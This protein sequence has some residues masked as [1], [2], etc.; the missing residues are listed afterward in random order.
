MAATRRLQKELA[1]LRARASPM[2][3]DIQ[4]DETNILSWNLLLLPTNDPYSDGAFKIEIVFPAEYPFK[5]PK[6]TFKTKIY[7]PNIDEKGQVCL[8]IISAENWKPATKT[9]QVLQALLALVHDPE[10][11]HPLRGDLA[12]LYSKNKKQFLTQAREYT[13]KHAEKRPT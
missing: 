13:K 3:S 6:I 8:P 10:P 12:E 1:D 9:D 11:E 4:V 5:P 7:H 2:V